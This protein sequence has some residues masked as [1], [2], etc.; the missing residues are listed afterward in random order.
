MEVRRFNLESDYPTVTEWY[1][2]WGYVPI[3]QDTLPTFGMIVSNDG[4]D[5]GAV[6]LYVTDGAVGLLEGSVLNPHAPKSAR[7]GAAAFLN[8]NMQVLA[9]KLGCIELWAISKDRFLTR[10]CENLGFDALPNDFKVLRKR[11]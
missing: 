4:Y 10:V 11:L 2:W 8:Q 6:W 1:K 9:K 5:I 7:K 3:P